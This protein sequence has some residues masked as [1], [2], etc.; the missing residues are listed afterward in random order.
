M[1]LIGN[2]RVI[3]NDKDG[4]FFEKGAVLTDGDSIKR[5]GLYAELKDACPEAEFIDAEGGIIMP[6]MINAHAHL[7]STLM[8]GYALKDFTPDS[9]YENLCKRSWKLDGELDFYDVA[10]GAY[11][12]LIRCIRNGVTT[13]FDHHASFKGVKGSLF[14]IAGAVQETGVR[15]CLCYETSQRCG[16][17]ACSEAIAE[18][19]SFLGYCESFG[20]SRLKAMFGLHA[21]FT[22]SD[23][24]ITDCVNRNAGRVGF[25]VH[26]SEGAEDGSVCLLN[27]GKTPLGRLSELGAVTDR[28]I[29]VH[30]VHTKDKE[31]DIIAASGAS[32]VNC[33]QSNM[34]NAVGAAAVTDMLNKGIRVGLGTDSFTFDMLE[35][36]RAFVLAERSRTGKCYTGVPQAAKLLFEN[37]REIA[38]QYFPK[39]IGTLTEGAPADVI[40]LDHKP[41][42]R[43]DAENAYP[44][45]ILGASGADCAMTMCAGRVLMRDRKIVAFD[46]EGIREKIRRSSDALWERLDASGDKTWF[47]PYGDLRK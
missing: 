19:E 43:F 31:L 45:L 44:Q 8:S 5:V 35:T 38:E 10:A 12:G 47:P 46:E 9:L 42:T 11:A 26:V 1:Y 3:T 14:A 39:G 34:S 29:L 36:A 27:Y 23:F 13:V 25:H 20:D 30:C 41:L 2:G 28:S 7:Y 22:L 37:N 21:P 40:V 32:V 17:K 15:G 33:P 16:F 4:S 6:G 24:D 18:N